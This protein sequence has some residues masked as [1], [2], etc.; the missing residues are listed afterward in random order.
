MS[1]NQ[2]YRGGPVSE[3]KSRVKAGVLAEAGDLVALISGKVETF[4]S[5]GVT[6][7]NFRT[8]F[9]GVLVQGTTRG[10]ETVDTPCLVYAFGEFEFPLPAAAGAAVEI[11]G[12]VAA[13][14]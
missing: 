3:V 9:L 1:D 8:N 14:A 13:N 11:G 6:A 4:T 7:A 10:T 5:A 12:L 2:R